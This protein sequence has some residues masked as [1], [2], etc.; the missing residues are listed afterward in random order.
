MQVNEDEV[1]QKIIL[2]LLHPINYRG[3]HGNMLHSND[4]HIH[5]QRVELGIHFFIR[6]ISRSLVYC[7]GSYFLDATLAAQI[8]SNGPKNLW[9]VRQRLRRIQTN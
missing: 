1:R 3:V 9:Q 6:I 4:G 7:F 2:E 5:W 8:K